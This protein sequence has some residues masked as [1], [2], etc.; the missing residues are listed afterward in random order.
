MASILAFRTYKSDIDDT[1]DGN[2]IVRDSIKLKTSDRVNWSTLRSMQPVPRWN[3]EHPREPGFYL[4]IIKPV[5][6]SRLVWELEA[7]YT[8][9]KGGQI[10]PDPLARPADIT[11]T[12]SL[13]EQPTFFDHN[14]KAMTTTAGEFISGIIERIPIVEYSVKK[15]LARDPDWMLTHMGAV[16]SDSINLRG[17]TWAP[18]TLLISAVSGGSFVTENRSTF[19]EYTISISADPRTWTQE[20]WNRG[21]VE[22]VQVEKLV[23]SG[24]SLVKKLV[25]VQSPIKEGDPPEPVQDPVPLDENGRAIGDYLQKDGQQPIK[26]GKLIKLNFQTQKAK[27]FASVLKLA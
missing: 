25:W 10:D 27:A 15:N 5:H 7:E 1:R 4:D 26:T 16:N 20:V 12:S 8:P 22:L 9:I 19:S 24:Q 2:N 17:L 14:R 18:K 23:F 11:F 21:T 3:Q 13:I 6:V